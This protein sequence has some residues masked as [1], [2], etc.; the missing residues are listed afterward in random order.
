M[1]VYLPADFRELRDS[2]ADDWR[3]LSGGLLPRERTLER[4][5]DGAAAERMFGCAD[6]EWRVF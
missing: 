1:D 4:G 2:A 5:V 3:D 6:P